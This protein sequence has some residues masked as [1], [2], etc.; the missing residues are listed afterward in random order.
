[1][2]TKEYKNCI[3]SLFEY[4]VTVTPNS[5]ALVFGTKELTYAEL[6]SKA[7]QLAHFLSAQNIAPE[8]L[9][10]I[11]TER[12]LE[13]IIGILGILKAGAAY[14][15]LDPKSPKDRLAYML[16][17]IDTPFLLTQKKLVPHFP[18]S[19]K[20]KIFCLD[21]D[22]KTIEQ[23]S[24]ENLDKPVEEDHLIYTIFTSGST[25]K[26][27]GVQVE[28][29]NVA[30]LIEAQIDFVQHPVKRF[31]YAYSFAFDGAVLLIYWTILQGA[32]LVIAEEDLEKDISKVAAYIQQMQISH[33]LT[34]P[35]LYSLLL[36]HAKPNQL[37]SLESISVAG[38]ACPGALV[39]RHHKRLNNAKLLNQYGPTEATVGCS[40]YSTPS[41]FDGVKVPIGK[42]IKNA[43]LY[44]LDDQLNK[45]PTGVSGEIYIGGKGV[46][47]CYLNRPDLTAER[48]IQNPFSSDP[49][50][51]LY[52]TGDLA[53]FLED[54]NIDFIGRTDYQVKLRGYRIELG[55]IEAI[56]AEHDLIR[57]TAVT[58][59]G[60]TTESQKLVAYIVL[61]KDASLTN[62]QLRSSLAKQ[63]PEY[64][65]PASFV[66]LDNMPLTTA[67][68]I[69]R[70]ALPEPSQDRPDLEHA[71]IAPSS[72][73]E[74]YLA[75][76]WSSIL[77]IEK[78]GIKDKFFELGGNSLQA[79]K[80]INDLQEKLNETIFIVTIFDCPTIESYAALLEK[81]YAKAVGKYFNDKKI[82]SDS[83]Q[84]PK[85]TNDQFTSF[86]QYIPEAS[87]QLNQVNEKNPP[88][89]FILSPPRSGTSLLRVMLAGH[90]KLFA[91][92][93]LQLLGFNT[94]KERSKAYSGK[95]SLWKEGTIR[96]IMELKQC[97]ADEAKA[98]FQKMEEKDFT[99]KA[100]YSLFQEWTN[101]RILVDKSPSYALD[102]SILQK[103][104]LDFDKAIYIHLVRHP[105]PMIRSFERMHMD[106]VMYLNQHSFDAQQLGELIWT[107]S[108]E[109]ILDFLSTIPSNRQF[110]I[111][112]EDLVQ[113]PENV[114]KGLCQTI[115]LDYHPNLIAPYKNV[116][117]KM[118]DGIYKDSKPMGDIRFLEH[119][120]IKSQLANNWKAVLEDNFLSASTWNVAK[121]FNYETPSSIEKSKTTEL[122]STPKQSNTKDSKETTNDIAIIGMS[123]RFPGAKNIYEF[124]ENLKSGK[125]VSKTFTAEELAAAGVDP[126]LIND[127]SFV[128]RGMILDDA[129][130]FDATFF[131]YHPKEAALMDPQHRI[132]LEC[133]Y[134]ALQDAGY[135]PDQY[136]GS[137][138]VIGGI[139]R[140]T[141][142]VN[143]VMTHPQYFKS[144][145]DFQKG[146]TLEKDFPAT[147]VA[148]KLNLKGPA[149]NVQTACSSSGVAVHLACQSLQTGDS[150]MMLV[151]GGRIQPPLQAGHVHTEG[152]A[153]SPDGYCRAFDAQA[154]GMVRGNGMSFIV[155]K[156]L[157]QAIKDGDTI[158]AVIKGTAINNDGADKIGF[159]AP[160]IKGQSVAMIRAYQKAGINPETISYIEAHGTGT[161]IGDPIEIASLTRAFGAF[162]NKKK[163]CPIGSVKTNIGHL[164]AGA[165]IAGIIKTVLALKHEL[166]PANLHFEKP[167]PQINF[168]QTP[169]YVNNELSDWKK[170]ASPRRAAVSSFGLGGTNAH[171]VLEEAPILEKK[172]TKKNTQLLVLSAKTETALDRATIELGNFLTQHPSIDLNDVAYTLQNGRSHF[173][174]K[175]FLVCN[176]QQLA[177]EALTQ[178]DKRQ[179]IS[180]TSKKEEKKIVFMFPGGGAQHSNMGRNLYDEE[181]VFKNAV[182]ECLFILKDQHGLN[183]RDILYP[184]HLENKPIENPLHG[185][186]LLFTIEYA[187]AQLWL[188][189][190]I[191]PS[192]MIGHSLG[193]YT[194]A[195]IAGVISLEDSIALVT[196]RG[197][198]FR[199]LPE[200]GM[201]SIPLPEQE[202]QQYITGSLSFAAINKPDLCV[203]SGAANMIDAVKQQLNQK[204]IHS[205]RLHIKVAAHSQEVEPILQ[206]FKQFLKTIKFNDPTI[207][208]ISNVTGDWADPA[209]IQTPEYW[210]NHL[211]QTVRFSDGIQTVLALPQRLLLEVGPGQTLSTFTRQHPAK[212]KNHTILASLK[213]PKEKFN[214][215]AF[216]LKSLGQLW[217]EDCGIKWEAFSNVSSTRISLP[218][219]PFEKTS[220]WIA[221]KSTFENIQLKSNTMNVPKGTFDKS[222]SRKSLVNSKLKDIFNELSGIPQSEM[223]DHATFLEL[224]FDSL[225]LTQA[226]SK[227]KKQLSV[228]IN[229][230]Q[231]FDEAPSFDALAELI[232]EQLPDNALEHE[233]EELNK[234]QVPSTSLPK[235][236]IQQVPVQ[237]Q[238]TAP[239]TFYQ[240][241]QQPLQSSNVPMGSLEALV[242]KQL[243]LMEQQ[244]A[245]LSGQTIVP[246]P[247]VT[248]PS[249]QQQQIAAPTPPKVPNT[250]N[251]IP[252]QKVERNKSNTPLQVKKGDGSAHGPWKP[253]DKKDDNGLTPQ[254]QQYL[255]DLINR[256][257]TRTK[258]SKQLT[259]QQRTHLADPRS[260]TGFMKLWKEMIYQIAVERS[261]GSKIWDV[262]GNEYV[263]YRMAFGISLF[264][265]T[266]DFVQEAVR[267]QLD[268]GFELGVLTPLAR[269]VADLLCEL[270]G[271]DRV[272]LVNTGSEAVSA[273]VR[274]ARTTT[275]KNKIAVFEGDY[276]G[277]ADEMLVRSVQRN[278]KSVSVPVSPG[279]P[280]FLVENVVVLKYDDPNVIDI[281]LENA[282]DLAAVIIEP[283][284][285]AY[286]HRQHFELIKAVRK[287]TEENDVA[288]IFDEMI[289]GFR[290]GMGGAQEW[291][292]VQADIVAYGKII[293]GGLPMA[294]VAGKAKYMDAF[295]GGMWQFGDASYPEA[296]VTFF[297]G[298]FVRHPLSMAASFAALSAIKEGGQ[299]MYDELNL[300][301]A[302]FA[303]RLKTLF[304]HSK[305]PLQ[306]LSSASFL[307]VKVTDDNPLS[308]LFFF[309]CRLKGVHI[310]EKAGLV[311]T[312]HTQEDFDFT[313]KVMEESI[314]EMQTAGFFKITVAD[315]EDK[316]II[317][318]PPHL[319]AEN[320]SQLKISEKK[321]IAL[322]EGQKEVWVEQQIGNEA[323]AAYNLSADYLF[324]GTFYIDHFKRALQA[325]VNRHEAL[326][327]V[328][329][330]EEVSQTILPTLTIE[331]PLV[332]LSMLSLNEQEEKLAALRFEESET[333]LDIFSGPLLRAKLVRISDQKHHFFLTVHHG[334]ADGWSC[335]IIAND[336]GKFYTAFCNKTVPKLEE[337]KQLSAFVEEQV[338][339]QAS[340]EKQATENY[341]VNQFKNDIPILEFPT[342]RSRPS[343]KTYDA[344]CEKISIKAQDFQA[345]KS[346]SAKQGTTLFITLFAAFQTY[347][348][349][350]SGQDDFVL[351]MVAASQTTNDNQTLVGHG[352]NLLPIRMQ[353]DKNTPFNQ[354]LKNVRT[355][356]LDA[357]DHQ[358]YTLGTLV[359]KLN[360]ARDPSRQPIISI[361]FNLDSDVGKLHF[362]NLEAQLT[363]IPRNYETFDIFINVKPTTTGVDF[364]WIYNTDLFNKE[365]IQR[366]LLEVEKLLQSIIVQAQQPLNQLDILPLAQKSILLN[367]WNNTLQKYP[368]NKTIQDLIEQIA[369]QYPHKTACA[370]QY[371]ELTYEQLN[372]KANKL[373]HYLITAGLQKG[374]FVGVYFNRTP[375]L[376]VSLLATIKAGGVYVPL[377]P[378]NP[379]DRLSVII[380]DT[381]SRFLLTHQEL[382]NKIPTQDGSVI[383]LEKIAAELTKLPASNP[384]IGVKA[385]DYAYI[386]YTS[387]STGKPK[388]V[389]IQHHQVIDH[390]YAIIDAL[391]LG[392]DET[393][394]SVASVAFDPS[395]QD[396]FMPLF[397][398]SKV[399]LVDEET[400]VNG[401][402]LSQL[403][404]RS[405]ATLMQATPATW[406]MLLTADWEG[407]NLL[408]ILCGGEGLNKDLANK[409][410]AKSKHLYNI[411]GPTETT[412]WSTLKKLEGD[413]LLTKA[414]SGYEP[415]G[416][417]INNVQVY[418][419][420]EKMQVVPIGAS[421]EIYIGGIGV[422]KEG[423]FKRP[424][425][426]VRKFVPSPFNSNEKLYRTGDLARYLPNGD[427][428][429]LS[430]A[431]FQV[432]IRGFRIELGEIEATIAQHSDI[433]QNVVVVRED[434]PNDKRLV[435]YLI[436]KK[437]TSFDTSVLKSFLKDKLPNYMIPVAFVSMES[438]PMTSSMKINRN[439]LPIPDYS[440]SELDKAYQ[441]PISKEEE[442]LTGL[443]KELLGQEKIGI[444]DNFYELGGHSLIAVEMIAKIKKE[445]GKKLPLTCL[446]E[447]ATIKD[448]AEL[449][450]DEPEE[451]KTKKKKSKGPLVTIQ[452]KGNKMP[453]YLIH[454]AGLH[455][456]MYKTLAQ[457]MAPDQPIYGF[458]AIGLNGEAKPLDRIEKIAAAYIKEMFTIDPDGPYALAGYSFGGLIA[459]E[460]AK[461][462]K[463]Q[464]KEVA[465]LGMFDTVVRPEITGEVESY[466]ESLSTFG[467]KVA[468]NLSEI[469]KSPIK[470]LKYK[471]N[472]L[473]RR[474]KRWKYRL[475]HNEQQELN[476][477]ETD[478]FALVDRMNHIAFQHYK[479]TPYDGAIHLFRAKER[480]FFMKDFEHL[481]W[482]PYAKDGIIVKEIPGDHLYMFDPPNGQ[483]FAR[484][485]Q[486]CLD[487]I[488]KD[489]N[490]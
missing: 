176:N 90:P 206:E 188:S 269:K 74:Q 30:N 375:D 167:N 303:E 385:T 281:I 346:F 36:E 169:F 395:V 65:I 386:N 118:T 429:Y 184:D 453:I 270:S 393:I 428:E 72:K 419:L 481:G 297:G 267:Q 426:N 404:N 273:S 67:G 84:K 274:A 155:L 277:I 415:I 361:L 240:A 99:T 262:D 166:L 434:Q 197:H 388:G 376:I 148:Y 461:Q 431:D 261:K 168:D 383:F 116:E 407:S 402:E 189:W 476:K 336:L 359:K 283:I 13:M 93:E 325:V 105:Y 248:S 183:L 234:Q 477:A 349:R 379:K 22:W 327:S 186:T 405:K 19:Q 165:C 413:R 278:G 446:V 21:T 337:P 333:P 96:T 322:T 14:V 171:I 191:V 409:L 290:L 4:Q 370:D 224:G 77:G 59:I 221:P 157:D 447:H 25:G 88:A 307:T 308:R 175:R 228:N 458:H 126:Q 414:D 26:P 232:D 226:V 78:I 29:K 317:I 390:H 43:Q 124:W 264:G 158:H 227:I 315:V 193:E 321:K 138:G 150:D 343:L 223:D 8:T 164:D 421:G 440:S 485:L 257:N 418:L 209:A 35:S 364:E 9:I 330:K 444:N 220:H 160:S 465:M 49:T 260:I 75:K 20:T 479:L 28:H 427:L 420:D 366:R 143:N 450:E 378:V 109:N 218:S 275:F 149:I 106:Q 17:E 482:G 112:Y 311:S 365:T 200:G 298:T 474:F 306:I 7:N 207:P 332:D 182:D 255:E 382:E 39:K 133:A 130:C 399:F 443:W 58:I 181:A 241:P 156:K 208:I 142:L 61:K 358:N 456:L 82:S 147:R 324:K 225:F 113:K 128:N 464:G 377:D 117:Q 323:S 468:W 192:E 238:T 237:Q 18:S 391:D 139:A 369:E 259:Q 486:Q 55:E 40:I 211:R 441:A 295:D 98:L 121:N 46:A 38:E 140:N 432:K 177:S 170:G 335:G 131:G 291:F 285:A 286:P 123:G 108:H 3:H 12:S 144:I 435:A 408:T 360:I 32:T 439:K 272:T 472:T 53:C 219:Y 127:P 367:E 174:H 487:E 328:F 161:R 445:R 24:T 282:D 463:A 451:T 442:F 249:I 416:R 2:R 410:I 231:L 320:P 173:K 194:A 235:Q 276:H 215:F 480:R 488:S 83:I 289:T 68:K 179:L 406:K 475:T 103:A 301:T 10:A 73:V 205:T 287:V 201:L 430:R 89:I 296:G 356:V 467:K 302:R 490:S 350:L 314:R 119:K 213:H 42:A 51:R 403:I 251:D 69:D 334:I 341:W 397:L 151:G 76:Q 280:N 268:K 185:I 460:I 230:R 266:P 351:G 244:L 122:Q 357:F 305:V 1:M 245:L 344:A 339:Y 178:V 94:L 54:G 172:P 111:R 417:P 236:P 312:A 347:I 85:L 11:S 210:C 137:I 316:N 152:H 136:Q 363:P 368:N 389:L 354:H 33:L 265:H 271:M 478:H 462:L 229:F 154:N 204:E 466:Y 159:T 115:G 256:Y 180:K 95:F 243:Q 162:T 92:N 342:D 471:T 401:F 423:Y 41:D 239:Q 338:A 214:D 212:T 371:N 114:M 340:P 319:Q 372:K 459:F 62:S 436:T 331:L 70:K 288:L 100:V 489:N 470:N 153:L 16:D 294:A 279:I 246:L 326:R 449:I 34:F 425:L 473:Q 258:G 104:E 233:L 352:V 146:I 412:I 424:E 66:F 452:G 71:Y 353:V 56:I 107:K 362:D 253:I 87:L 309:F 86:D 48:F 387:G 469:T 304:I 318:Y 101:D 198:L 44:I 216:I 250:S 263:D 202:V 299:A 394:L 195:C 457:H 120:K 293:S 15:P 23:Y 348:H 222:I 132:Y 310:T 50:D 97:N 91:A 355:K 27:K 60:D 483:E 242:N 217:L 125:D 313:F 63:L 47:R 196:K 31:L 37:A 134:A 57:D 455:V 381:Q 392:T 437:G 300:K 52:K 187:T 80:F 384:S 110:R 398:G 145:E 64:M 438:F 102:P 484:I 396:F 190:G 135:N 81:D 254:Q 448:L 373:A 45:V 422:A 329:N 129:D 247:N 454:G 400:K 292:G 199:T 203:V 433:S 141:Y 6:N 284:Q 79:A 345:L 411:Y 252:T 5:I 374:E 380:E 163:F